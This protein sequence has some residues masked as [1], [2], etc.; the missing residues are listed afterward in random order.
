MR[1]SDNG[2]EIRGW[3]FCLIIGVIAM[4]IASVTVNTMFQK[5]IELEKAK[6]AETE[7]TKRGHWLWGSKSEDIIEEKKIVED[8]KSERG[9]W[10]WGHWDD[11]AE[12]KDVAASK[13]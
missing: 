13:E 12:S 9:H 7:H 11:V 4:L 8:G 2:I 5:T 10:L 1:L 3:Q 6:V